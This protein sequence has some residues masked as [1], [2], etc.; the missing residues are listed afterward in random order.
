MA[1]TRIVELDTAKLEGNKYNP[2]KT[3]DKKGL[4]SLEKSLERDGQLQTILVRPIDG[5]KYEVVAGMRR[6]LSLKSL[7]VKKAMCTVQEMDDQTAM[8]RAFKENV[9]REPLS[10]VDEAMWFFEMLGLKEE[11]LFISA[12]G[13]KLDA[14]LPPG[15]SR[16]LPTA[17]HPAVKNLATEINVERNVIERRLPLLSLPDS[18][19]RQVGQDIEIKKAEALA[20]LRLVEDKEEAQKQMSALWKQAAEVDL[21]ALNARVNNILETYKKKADDIFKE[22]VELERNLSKR[23]DRI[24]SEMKEASEWIEP[25]SKTGLFEQLPETVSENIKIAKPKQTARS[26]FE[27]LDEL[28]NAITR[29]D[30]LSEKESKLTA[31]V[32]NLYAGQKSIEDNE[33]AYCGTHVDSR[34]LEKRI[35]SVEEEKK[36]VQEEIKEK[37][38]LRGKTEKVKRSLGLAIREFEDVSHKY[39]TALKTLTTAKKLSKEQADAK[40][41]EFLKEV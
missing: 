2:R 30:S 35:E 31:K 12:P 41:E 3:M 22:L 33:C 18:M 25:G 9:E 7:G 38:S 4:A 14:V 36:K 24:R 20:R 16:P 15:E 28:V 6:Y 10:P 5:G 26:Y 23:K 37:D 13:M 40:R 21:E 11:Q 8:Q 1:T 19:Q 34:Q 39:E 27:Y 29:D 17:E 32:N